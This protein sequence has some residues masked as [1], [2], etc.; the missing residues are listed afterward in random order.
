MSTPP[1][2]DLQAFAAVARLGSFRRAAV[3]IGVSASALSHTLKGLEQ[4]LGL[5]EYLQIVAA[6]NFKQ[7]IR[8]LRAVRP[9]ICISSDFIVG[10]PGETEDDFKQLIDFIYEAKIDRIGVFKYENVVHAKSHEF[11]D[12]IPQ[13][14]I[15]DRWN[16]LMEVAQEVSAER[17]ATK[18]GREIDVIV[19]EIDEEGTII[20]R[21]IWDAPE[22]DGNIFIDPIEGVK[23]GDVF[24]VKVEDASEYDLFGVKP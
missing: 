16:R 18:I 6:T 5:R 9:D 12:Q 8:K 15:D 4:R 22:V 2:Q 13:E 24:K 19:D 11:D 20:A 21:T 7:R 23:I 3:E 17:L 1:L 10:F 14:I